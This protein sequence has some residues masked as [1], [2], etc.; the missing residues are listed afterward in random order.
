MDAV[1]F[2][3]LKIIKFKSTNRTNRIGLPV[4]EDILT[5]LTMFLSPVMTSSFGTSGTTGVVSLVGEVSFLSTSTVS[6]AVK[7]PEV[8]KFVKLPS[9]VVLK[10]TKNPVY[11]PGVKASFNVQDKPLF[12]HLPVA[13][14]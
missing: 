11:S 4:P 8:I 13:S 9:P 2:L 7:L 3:R 10:I 14:K 6:F 1:Y 12:S 5:S